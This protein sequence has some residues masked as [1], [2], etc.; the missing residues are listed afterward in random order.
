MSIHKNILSKN[1]KINNLTAGGVVSGLS[2]VTRFL[3]IIPQYPY[4]HREGEKAPAVS[5]IN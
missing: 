2:Q 4:K 5:G 1:E 3:F